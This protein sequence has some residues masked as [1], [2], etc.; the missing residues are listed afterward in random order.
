M[1]TALLI[2]S[3]IVLAVDNVRLRIAGRQRKAPATPEIEGVPL[4]T[5]DDPRWI[6]DEVLFVGS[7]KPKPVMRMGVIYVDT[8]GWVFIRRDKG[9]APALTGSQEYGRA[10]WAAHDARRSLDSMIEAT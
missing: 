9:N 3:I 7:T 10:V 5:P 1:I 6:A 8:D 4:P 2:G